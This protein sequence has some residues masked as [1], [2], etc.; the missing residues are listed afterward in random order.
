[1]AVDGTDQGAGDG[2]QHARLSEFL[3]FVTLP[4]K[5]PVQINE[6]S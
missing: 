3:A 5:V 2:R 1:V 6:G 4:E